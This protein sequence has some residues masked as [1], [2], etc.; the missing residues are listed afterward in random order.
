MLHEGLSDQWPPIPDTPGLSEPHLAISFHQLGAV[1][2]GRVSYPGWSE[3]G[4]PGSRD[5]QFSL[6]PPPSSAPYLDIVI[7]TTFR[8]LQV[9]LPEDKLH[10][11]PCGYCDH[12]GPLKAWGTEGTSPPHRASE[13]WGWRLQPCRTGPA[14]GGIRATCQK[15]KGV[16]RAG[17]VQTLALAGDGIAVP[18]GIF[19]SVHSRS[20]GDVLRWVGRLQGGG[21]SLQL[22]HWVLLPGASVQ[23]RGHH[24]PPT[25]LP[26]L[27]PALLHHS[28]PLP[29]IAWLGTS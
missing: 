24:A 3:P 21:W 19:L 11:V 25:S 18:L 17:G 5:T 12:S 22:L 26:S 14:A 2:P 1:S 13:G 20:Q 23:S 15:G 8:R 16:C 10:P 9:K 6:C 29:G 7:E 27:L 4:S 28:A